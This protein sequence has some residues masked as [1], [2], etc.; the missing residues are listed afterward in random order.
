[1]ECLIKNDLDYM[2]KKFITTTL[3]Y[4]N[5]LHFHIGAAFEF[6][7]ADIIAAYWRNKI[8]DKNV[9]FNIGSDEHGQKIFQK[10]VE[11][12]YN[13]PQEYCDDIASQ[14][15]ED[16]K[17]LGI[18]YDN[19]YRTTDKVHK[20][21]TL[22]FIEDKLSDFI[23]E[24]DYTGLYC[25]G[26]E[27]Y[28][29]DKE[30]V[31]GKCSIH[32]QD[33][34]SLSERVK[35]LDIQRIAPLIKDVLV[36]KSLSL[37]LSNILSNDFDF[38]ITRSNVEWAIPFGEGRTLH[39]WAEALLNYIF[40]AGYYQNSDEFSQYWGNS[41]Q[42]CGKD[43]LKFQAYIFQAIL[44]AAGI[45]Q[46]SEILVHGTILD[47]NGNKMS[48]SLG[49]VVNPLDQLEKY[50]LGPLRYYLT[51]GLNTYNDSSFNEED[52]VRIWNSEVV[53]GYGNLISRVLHL[54][55]IQGIDVNNI[56]VGSEYSN[57]VSELK[58]EVCDSF[59]S[60]DFSKSRELI[61]SWVRTLNKRINDERPFDLSVSNREDIISEILYAVKE[62]SIFYSFILKNDEIQDKINLGKKVILF[63]RLELKHDVVS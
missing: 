23:Y 59:E 8:G 15:K 40:A 24:R 2:E 60:Y 20:E 18:N 47:K 62:L 3:P 6:V 5:A 30:I 32:G 42:L 14:W 29:T 53:G 35:C 26:C 11:C 61:N 52:L 19:F 12:G 57:K 4:C 39:C 49:N 34:Q 41:L 28:K 58:K 13:S 45:P 36:D 33:L 54:A 37:E 50:G 63:P 55:D 1:M 9:Y 7:L 43:N 51:F 16:C 44:I 38:P 56:A 46:T 21:N 25:V 10:S 27:S 22:K 17:K 31:D 48:K